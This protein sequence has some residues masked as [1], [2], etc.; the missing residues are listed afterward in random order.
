M[1]CGSLVPLRYVCSLPNP[2]C[3][4]RTSAPA[5]RSVR[6][7]TLR[8]KTSGGIKFIDRSSYMRQGRNAVDIE[9]EM[10]RI[11]RG[12]ERR[13]WSRPQC[14][15]TRVRAGLSH[16]LDVKLDRSC[17]QPELPGVRFD[18]NRKSMS[19]KIPRYGSLHGWP[20]KSSKESLRVSGG[21]M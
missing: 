16:P 12:E 21:W 7:S 9:S 17:R 8:L 19:S 11:Q 10:L 6:N 5:R 1:I 20:K 15:A 18:C 13:Q 14:C 3:A 4:L 2:F